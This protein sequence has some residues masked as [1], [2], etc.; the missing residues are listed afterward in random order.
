MSRIDIG[1]LEALLAVSS[2]MRDSQVTELAQLKT[3]L[4]EFLAEQQLKGHAV[5]SAKRYYEVGYIPLIQT[6]SHTLDLL[7]EKLEA[8]IR[9]FY[10][11]VDHTG[12]RLDSKGLM[13]LEDKIDHYNREVEG[14]KQRMSAVSESEL[15]PKL[16]QLNDSV[17]SMYEEKELLEKYLAFE[18]SHRIFFSEIESISYNIQSGL[19]EL[20]NKVGFSDIHTGYDISGLSKH[21]QEFIQKKNKE[22]DERDKAGG[23]EAERLK[24]YTII[25]CVDPMTGK[26]T[27]A[28]EKNGLGI[29]DPDL[30]AY[31]DKVGDGLSEKDYH[32]LEIT[33]KEWADRVNEAWKRN[34]TDYFSGNQYGGWLSS[35]AHGQDFMDG[36]KESG[37]YDALWS[38]GTLASA[39]R[40]INKMN[41]ISKNSKIDKSNDVNFNWE[42]QQPVIGEQWNKYFQEKYGAENVRWKP[43]SFE[44]IIINP[45]RLYGST[46]EEIRSILGDGWIEGVYGSKGTGWKFTSSE[47]SIFYHGGGGVHDGT[48]YGFS[49]GVNGRVKIVKQK[50]GYNPTSDD[51]AT[52]IWLD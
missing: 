5:E 42:A 4:N 33:P 39:I 48:Y 1:E 26:V 50:D 34:G 30:Q 49:N 47:G 20:T 21:W 24:E 37:V 13:E 46:K 38:L 41:N 44:D 51:K 2:R 43:T 9:H 35:L 28:I 45:E 31:L 19:R 22:F 7:I 6:T 32:I 15:T 29:I 23:E 10:E 25:K 3:Y 27:W 40:N 17:F 18:E 36:I 16:A 11:D 14:L 52:I 8:Y 12:G